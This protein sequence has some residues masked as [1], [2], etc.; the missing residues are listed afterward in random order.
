MKL[1]NQKN[2]Y[3]LII[4]KLLSKEIVT[5][6]APTKSSWEWPF[7]HVLDNIVNPQS[8]ASLP[9]WQVKNGIAF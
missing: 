7:P 4:A 2:V 8:S 3:I 1:L 5:I 9:V 6:C